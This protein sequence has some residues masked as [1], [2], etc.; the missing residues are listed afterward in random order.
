MGTTVTASFE[1]RRAAEM[2]VERLVQELGCERTDIFIAAEGDDNSAGEREAGSDQEAG[3]PSPATRSD[4][5][6]NGKVVVSVDLED[7]AL[8]AKVTDAFHEFGA[9][10]LNQS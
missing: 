3:A 6:L 1:T 2:T 5:A 4:A 7:P 8:A 10:D 9:V